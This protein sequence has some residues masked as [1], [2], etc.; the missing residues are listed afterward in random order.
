[1]KAIILSAGIGSRLG[2]LTV[3][4]PKCLLPIGTST[5]LHRQIAMLQACGIDEIVVVTGYRSEQ[6]EE[7]V[8]SIDGVVCVF[9]PFYRACNVLGSFWFGQHRLD[10]DFIFL[11]GDTIFEASILSDLV[12]ATDD[13]TLAVEFGKTDAEAMKVRV[14]EGTLSRIS[15]QMEPHEAQG[16]FIGLARIAREA[17]G[18]I[19][20][21]ADG[22]MRKGNL[23]SFFEA[24][25]QFM[26][27]ADPR[28]R[29]GMI[30][31]RGRF[32]REI[33]FQEDYDFA[34]RNYRP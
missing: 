15:K 13:V 30:D 4:E 28:R 2:P 7:A 3:K 29:F 33:D 10:G 17:S 21:I 6:V 19:K 25:L 1:M 31:T 9:N 22:E 5:I 34:V 32:W 26:L 12:A 24:V 8:R 11:H 16:E 18:D 14:E 27:D 23:N 20:K